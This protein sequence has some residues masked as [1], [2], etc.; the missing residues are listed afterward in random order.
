MLDMS[1]DLAKTRSRGLLFAAGFYVAAGLYLLAFTL[2]PNMNLLMLLLLGVASVL[3]GLGLYMLKRWAFWLAIAVF[4]LLATFAIS[5]L[6][7][8][9]SI[10]SEEASL[11]ATLLNTSLAA[12]GA[13]SFLAFFAVLDNRARSSKSVNEP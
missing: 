12:L 13:L 4:P 1:K 6:L 5:T 8:S 7:F 10:P 2:T 11:M 9:M 3:A